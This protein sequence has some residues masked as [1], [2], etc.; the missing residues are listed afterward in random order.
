MAMF[1]SPLPPPLARAI[2]L[3]R[4]SASQQNPLSADDQLDVLREDCQRYGW[5][6][7][8]EYKDE[9]KSGL[10]A[11]N[12]TGYI[13]ALAAIEEGRADVLCVASLD[14][15]GRNSRE[16][17]DANNRLKDANA[18]IY[19]HDR[20]VMSR[21]EFALYA[22]MAQMESERLG[23][24]T[25]RGRRAAA[26]RGRVMGDI[27]YGYRA[28][29][30][31]D[32]AGNVRL[33]SRGHQIRRVEID[34]ERAQVVRRVHL[35][36]QAGRSA[37]QIA[38]ALT[39]EGVPP[40]E[41]GRLW[42]PMTIMGDR[43]AMTG[44]LRNPMYVGKV[45]HGK[46]KTER[47][48]RTG[49][50]RRRVADVADR[51][52]H[53]MPWLRIVPQEVWDQNQERLSEL[54][55]PSLR[56]HRRPKYLLT[57]LVKCGVCGASFV[58]VSSRM[59]CTARQLKACSNSR[60]V[61]RE[62]LERCV[63]DGLVGRL[64]QPSVIS[65]FIPEY[66]R[67]RGPAMNEADDRHHRA[68]QRRDEAEREIANIIQQVKA[69]A[70]GYAAKLL[71]ENL[72]TLGAE[73]ERLEREVA[74]GPSQMVGAL[75]ANVIVDRMH[76]LFENL[77]EA[78][79][80]DER[81]AA[82][83]RDIVRSLITK[84]SVTPTDSTG[85][86]YDGRATGAVTVHVE[87]EV[88]RLVDQAMLDRKIM[89]RR[90]ASLM[91]GLPVASFRFYVDLDRNMSAD[92]EG[93]WRD[94]AVISRMLDDADWPIPFQEMVEAINDRGRPTD[95]QEA[96]VDERRAKV[97][98]AQFRRREWVRAVRLGSSHGWV[99]MERHLSD[100]Q[101]RARY[102]A[103][104]LFDPPI[105]IIRL[106]APEADMVELGANLEPLDL[107]YARLDAQTALNGRP[108]E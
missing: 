9:A 36:Y 5:E 63:L 104:D 18:V 23:E 64:A 24:R 78:L 50:I 13:E 70:Q 29:V 59:A 34:P 101:W 71:N 85:T 47:D 106:S 44:L 77:G 99:W 48:D 60:R 72:E 12:R 54:R 90:G 82:R 56:D 35:D 55:K 79:Q 28:V 17:H 58:Q 10:K 80:G 57:G 67:E 30:E 41:A 51:I 14:R 21:F 53:D 49:H 69:G 33:N 76:A 62:D 108:A 83:A 96:E 37:Q 74:A 26:E 68:V 19:T 22:E 40:P 15:L 8:A 1:N 66:L 73:K 2:N 91:H 92:Q 25:T 93:L 38:V 32:D 16:L 75:S 81:D 84:V 4:F 45:I 89:H 107:R 52:E 61:K 94:A 100:D 11:T 39:A 86:S 27:P 105:A 20:G 88:G 43:R 87:G 65:W 42:Q 7:I 6:V 103:R 46:M 3:G 31:H 95:R 97:A 98:L 102:E